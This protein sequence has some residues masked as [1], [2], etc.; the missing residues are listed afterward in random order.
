M[1]LSS[2]LDFDSK[3]FLEIG[4]FGISWYA[5]CILTGVILAVVMGV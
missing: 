3:Y 2:F 5:F 4:N 1:F